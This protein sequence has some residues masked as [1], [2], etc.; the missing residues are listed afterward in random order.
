MKIPLH[1]SLSIAIAFIWALPMGGMR[2]E[3]TQ[4]AAIPFNTQNKETAT[5]IYQLINNIQNSEFDPETNLTAITRLQE[6]IAQTDFAAIKEI[7]DYIRDSVS[8]NS[9]R[10]K[11]IK[12]ESGSADK[13]ETLDIKKT[14]GHA[15]A[16]LRSPSIGADFEKSTTKKNND[17]N[18][19]GV[20]ISSQNEVAVLDRTRQQQS[21]SY[22]RL[23]IELKR[24]GFARPID[25]RE[26]YGHW[27]WEC[28]EE[29]GTYEFDFKPDG[30]V[31]VKLKPESFVKWIGNGFSNR[32]RGEWSL[33]YRA[34][35][36]KMNDV[37][38]AFFWKQQPL[39]FF[40][41]REI[42]T[43]DGDRMILAISE[44]NELKRIKEKL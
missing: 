20:S 27:K 26:V 32:G 17:D 28:K 24:L 38:L 33:D 31:N 16:N 29:S 1:L 2:G 4:R 34:L 42:V 22:G 3:E 35:S 13:R 30:T 15:S 39:L 11:D 9:L 6:S 36:V 37:N 7:G 8:L 5:K 12:V 19:S 43:I 18:T 23:L 14:A 40:T 44:D 25:P 10:S 41:D 21:T